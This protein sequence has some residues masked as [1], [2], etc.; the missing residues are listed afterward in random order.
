M[1]LINIVRNYKSQLATRTKAAAESEAFQTTKRAAEDAAKRAKESIESI[2]REDVERVAEQAK[3]AWLK[4]D[5][6]AK[7]ALLL[8][9]VAY[10]VAEYLPI[11]SKLPQRIA[12]G[13]GG[14]YFISAKLSSAGKK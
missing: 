4:F 7:M 1:G 14:W 9:V 3:I 11:G 13:V 2:E 10:F 6:D 12:V 8:F 5:K